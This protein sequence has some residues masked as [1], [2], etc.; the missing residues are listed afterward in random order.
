MLTTGAATTAGASAPANARPLGPEPATPTIVDR[1]WKAAKLLLQLPG[2]AGVL[3]NTN[4]R[5]HRSHSSHQSHY[6]GSSGGTATP[7]PKP[8]P[9]RPAEA[10]PSG[11]ATTLDLSASAA[12]AVTGEVLSVDLATRTIAI[13]DSASNRVTFSYRDDSKFDSPAGVSVRFDDY[14]SANSGR[15]PIALRDKVRLTWRMATDGKTR[16][17]STISKTP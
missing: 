10:P 15:V 13:R 17:L 2:T 7:A 8:T 6:S 9:P 5:S 12:N 3:V 11:S 4:H 14:A 1:S 16:V